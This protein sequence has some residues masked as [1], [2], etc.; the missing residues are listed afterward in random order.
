MATVRVPPRRVTLPCIADLVIVSDPEQI[1]QVAA[2][3]QIDRLH[4]V[5]TEE[6]PWWVRTLFPATRFWDQDDNYFV[7]L[8]SST[9]PG[10]THR[11]DYIKDKLV[12]GISKEDVALVARLLHE[13]ALDMDLTMAVVNAVNKRFFGEKGIPEDVV[14]AALGT[15]DEISAGTMTSYWSAK[16]AQERVLKFIQSNPEDLGG[17]PAADFSHHIGA[18]AQLLTPACK[19]LYAQRNRD[20]PVL[21]IFTEH[22]MPLTKR[23]LRIAVEDTTVDG[24]LDRP[25]IAN[26]TVFI[27]DIRNASAATK[28]PLFTFGAGVDQRQCMFKLVFQQ[29]MEELQVLLYSKCSF[30]DV[31]CKC[32]CGTSLP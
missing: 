12:S 8:T 5:S 11:R 22:D 18:S 30:G 6:K 3:P 19:Y 13:G 17:C 31:W 14:K 1:R 4:A 32:L 20:R 21:D 25:A 15:V 26:R 16:R 29:F 27:L 7:P 2:H 23:T 10:Y 28:D 9:A 24:L